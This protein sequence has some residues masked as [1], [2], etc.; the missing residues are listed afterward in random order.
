MLIASSLINN[1]KNINNLNFTWGP[2]INFISGPNGS[3]KTNLL[4][5]LNILSGW[6]TFRSRARDCVNWSLDNGRAYLAAEVKHNTN[7]AK[8]VDIDLYRDLFGADNN[9]KITAQISSQINLKLDDK[10]ISSTDL[11]LIIPS[12]A[13]QPQDINLIEGSPAVRRLFID[14]LCALYFPPYAKRLAEFKTI[15]RHRAALLRQGRS[16]NVTDLPF[17]NLGGYVMEARRIVLNQL[18]GNFENLLKFNKLKA[19]NFKFC[20]VPEIDI[21]NNLQCNEYL[22]NLLHDANYINRERGAMRVLTGPSHD[23]LKILVNDRAANDALSRGQKRRLVLY[24][25]I[26][27]GYLISSRLRTRPVLLFDDLAAELD[28]KNLKICAEALLNTGWQIF[29]TGTEDLLPE[30]EKNIYA[31]A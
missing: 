20:L 15:A 3:G 18:R 13:F 7:L 5:A 26:A 14:K 29:I 16:V 17:A 28:N 10:K 27:A 6:G 9:Y 21:N 31:M 4:E 8:G 2:G 12:I 23:D 22:L 19:V 25:I 1:F 30:F 24:L 11:R